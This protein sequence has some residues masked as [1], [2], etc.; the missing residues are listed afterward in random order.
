MQ[1]SGRWALQ[2]RACLCEQLL[3]CSGTFDESTFD[4]RTVALRAAGSLQ[5]AGPKSQLAITHAVPVLRLCSPLFRAPCDPAPRAGCLL[6][7][8]CRGQHAAQ[9]LTPGPGPG[10]AAATLAGGVR[11]CACLSA[12]PAMLLGQALQPKPTVGPQHTALRTR[13]VHHR[14]GEAGH[15]TEAS[16]QPTRQVSCRHM[17]GRWAATAYTYIHTYN[18]GGTSRS[19]CAARV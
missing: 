4:E 17:L 13:M 1:H 10:R 15:A 11:G 9:P 12:V 5:A 18:A 7:A 19:Q 16:E 3:R 8:R 14:R 6:C 2:G